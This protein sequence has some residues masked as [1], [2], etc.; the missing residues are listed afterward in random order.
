MFRFEEKLLSK[1]DKNIIF[2]VMIIVSLAGI[3]IRFSM[4]DILSGDAVTHLLPWHDEIIQNGLSRQVGDYSFIY[5]FVLWIIGKLPFSALYSIK[6]LSCVFDYLLAVACGMIVYR[7]SSEDKKMKFMLAYSF[8]LL[9]PIVFLNSAAWAQC[10]SIFTAFAVLALFCLDSKR[11]NSA[12][13]CLG[14]S[15]SFKLQA[16]FILPIFLFVYFKRREFSIFRFFIVPLTMIATSLP[17]VFWE[18]SVLC[19][20]KIY[21]MQINEYNKLFMNY[22]SIWSFLCDASDSRPYQNLKYVAIFM[23]LCVLLLIITYWIKKGYSPDGNNLIMMTFILVFTCVITLPSMHERYGFP[24]EIL[25]III[26]ILVPKT[27]PLCVSLI[28]VSLHT[29]GFFLFDIKINIVSLSFVNLIVYLT[30]IIVLHREF[31]KSLR[32]N[33]CASI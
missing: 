20:F 32:K 1:I 26:A 24:Y 29:Y 5:Q 22:P 33:D 31:E 13:I 16:V 4:R 17:A 9:S 11:Y 14:I 28:A 21:Y 25:A 30:Y 18:R 12:M 19:G 6:L 2:I 8:V 10:D 23:S 3:I 7:I 27:I 15:L